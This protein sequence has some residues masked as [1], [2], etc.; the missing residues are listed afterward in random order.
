MREATLGTDGLNHAEKSVYSDMRHIPTSLYIDT[1]VFV[2]NGYRFDTQAFTQLLDTF[3]KGGIRLLIPEMMERELLRKF[4]EQAIKAA[5]ALINAHK[6]HPI[7]SL[8][9]IAIPTEEELQSKCYDEMVRQWETFKDHFI[10]EKLPIVGNLED[11]IDW[12]FKKEPPFSERKPKEFPDAFILSALEHYHKEHKANIA[13]ISGDDDFSKACTLRRFIEY[14]S[15]L[16]EYIK[17]FEP[18]LT[19]EDLESPLIDLTRP[20]TTEDLTELQAILGRGNEVTSIEVE[21]VLNLLRSRG[22]N[23]DYFFTHAKDGVW[24]KHLRSNGYFDNPPDSEE[25]PDGDYRAPFWPPIYY[26]VRVYETKP[27]RVLEIL[28]NLPETSNPHILEGIMDVILKVN[29]A[30]AFNRLSSRILSFVELP[31]ET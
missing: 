11:T 14:F 24:L 10:V 4:D 29:S 17:A 25:T 15:K 21:R 6:T 9:L 5:K 28:E 7:A 22:T 30:E 12:Y 2:R 13:V 19:S 18:E 23:Y 27:E 16:D 26:L 1:Q 20:I 3:V 31:D 8:S